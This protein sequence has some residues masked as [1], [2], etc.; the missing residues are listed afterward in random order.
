[1]GE[2]FWTPSTLIPSLRLEG[3]LLRS[4]ERLQKGGSEAMPQPPDACGDPGP[5]HLLVL[6]CAHPAA[7]WAW[8][9]WALPPLVLVPCWG[10]S[11]GPSMAGR[12]STVQGCRTASE[13]GLCWVFRL[14][15]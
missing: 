11:P 2:G 4:P 12:D 7:C 10:L 15:A 6:L 1:M 5:C 8:G 14:E 3:P 13:T 9:L